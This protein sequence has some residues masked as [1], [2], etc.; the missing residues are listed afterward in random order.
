MRIVAC[1]C[2][3]E[4]QRLMDYMD[5]S[6]QDPPRRMSTSALAIAVCRNV[7]LQFLASWIW[8][9]FD[10]HIERLILLIAGCKTGNRLPGRLPSQVG[11]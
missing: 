8:K 9:T 1:R 5:F 11:P 10:P 4:A 6:Q 3:S 2:R 7:L